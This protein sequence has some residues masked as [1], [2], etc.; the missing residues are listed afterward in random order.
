MYISSNVLMWNRWMIKSIITPETYYDY[1]KRQWPCPEGFHIFTSSDLYWIKSLPSSLWINDVSFMNYIKLPHT[2]VISKSWTWIESSWTYYVWWAC[3]QN[4]NF[5]WLIQLSWTPWNTSWVNRR[6]WWSVTEKTNW[7]PVRPI[8]DTPIK[9]DD[10]WV[11]IYDWSSIAEWAWIFWNQSLWLITVSSDWNSWWTIADKNLWATTVWNPW[12]A[13]NDNNRWLMYQYWNNHWFSYSAQSKIVSWPIDVTW[14]WPWNRYDS[15]TF[16]TATYNWSSAQWSTEAANLWWACESVE[17]K[18]IITKWVVIYP[19]QEEQTWYQEVEY[20]ESWSDW[21]EQ[22]IRM[23]FPYDN[24]AI[25]TYEID[26]SNVWSATWKLF[27]YM[28]SVN[29]EMLRIY[30]EACSI[31]QDMI[32]ARQGSFTPDTYSI[33]WR[34]LYEWW[35]VNNEVD[36]RFDLLS[37]ANF[38]LYSFK[39]YK[40]WVLF[41]DMIPCYDRSNWEIWMYD[42]INDVFYTNQWTWSF[43]KWPDVV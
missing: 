22:F 2:W 41:R 5:C 29:G 33:D 12:D 1:S 26:V 14:Y 7:S 39:A 43:I 3:N 24:W 11:I 17:Q 10:S 6:I 27:T 31:D 8:K 25:Y 15:D 30:R 37:D 34:Y 13:I 19:P 4:S 28:Q 36:F 35:F 18:H 9:P 23:M 20:I 40:D 16:V 42:T 21:N 32:P 38:R